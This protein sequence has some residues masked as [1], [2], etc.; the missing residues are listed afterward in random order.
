VSGVVGV[1][2]V[3]AAAAETERLLVA[4]HCFV[5]GVWGKEGLAFCGIVIQ[6]EKGGQWGKRGFSEG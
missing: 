1:A 3:G 2:E 6:G 4:L 5:V